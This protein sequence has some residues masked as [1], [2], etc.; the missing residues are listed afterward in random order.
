M[1]RAE[2]GAKKVLNRFT[3]AIG[4]SGGT[5]RSSPTSE[6]RRVALLHLVMTRTIQKGIL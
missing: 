3:A 6:W 2:A 4:M 1:L 5:G